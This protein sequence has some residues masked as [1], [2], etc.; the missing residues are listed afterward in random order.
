[1]A[2]D[3]LMDRYST[4]E[5]VVIM[6]HLHIPAPDPMTNPSTEA[7]AEFCQAFST[8]SYSI[9]GT[10]AT[11]GGDKDETKAFYDRLNAQIEQRLGDPAEARLSLDASRKGHL[12]WVKATVDKVT[13]KSSD[14]N[15]QIALV[16]NQLTYGGENGTRL[17]PMVVRSLG[18]E[19]AKG[20]PVDRATATTVEQ[21]FD[22]EKITG[23]LKAFLN[24]F[25][26]ERKMT[27]KH[28]QRKY[29][30]NEGNL[31]IAAFVQDT[32]N[33]RVLQAAFVKV[34]AEADSSR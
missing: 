4:K 17:H 8:P 18:G 21:T 33:R 5:F 19:K 31:S 30:I 2:F 24:D 3:A 13:G 28:Y 27:F 6:H 32:K 15:L 16:E 1:M 11:G 7:R 34:Q 10:M 29:E 9:D 22:I 23:E 20:F 26:K 14:L 25:E 12:I